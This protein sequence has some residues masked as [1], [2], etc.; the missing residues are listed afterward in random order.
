MLA[1]GLGLIAAGLAAI[2]V[3]GALEGLFVDSL[4]N[5]GGG[6]VP[7]EHAW[8]IATSLLQ[9]IAT[10]VV[11]F[12]VRFVIAAFLA[13]PAA[14]RSRHPQGHRTDTARPTRV[15]LVD[16]RG[17][18]LIGVDHLAARGTRAARTHHRC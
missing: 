8:A 3:R 9:S 17:A 6:E 10:T 14:V 18:A 1:Y 16:L 4:A 15:R 13:S 7:A 12:G 2:G 5:D 11:I